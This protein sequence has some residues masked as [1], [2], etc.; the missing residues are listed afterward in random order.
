MFLQSCE[1]KSGTE[2]LS[3]RLLWH[4]MNTSLM[5]VKNKVNMAVCI[6]VVFLNI[7]HPRSSTLL[8]YQR[9]GWVPLWDYSMSILHTTTVKLSC[10]HTWPRALTSLLESKLCPGVCNLICCQAQDWQQLFMVMHVSWHWKKSHSSWRSI[11]TNMRSLTLVWWFTSASL[12]RRSP[13]IWTWPFQLA[14]YNAVWP[15]CTGKGEQD[16]PEAMNYHTTHQLTQCNLTLA[17][18]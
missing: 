18:P 6:T 11:H 10:A 17:W 1:T 4:Y 16:R 13:T 9:G 5:I 8:V 15:V 14:L 3:L 2:S 12:L 7:T